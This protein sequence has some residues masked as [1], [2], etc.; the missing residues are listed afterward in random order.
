MLVAGQLVLSIAVHGG[1]GLPLLLRGSLGLVLGCAAIAAAMLAMAEGHERSAARVADLLGSRHLRSDLEAPVRDGDE[2]AGQERRFWRAYARSSVALCIFLAGILGI[3]VALLDRGVLAY[4]M[5]LSV[6]VA[7]L[8]LGS[9]YLAATALLAIR[10]DHVCL[11][12]SALLLAQLPGRPDASDRPPPPAR[13]VV[14]RSPSRY[15]HYLDR[16]RPA[17]D[18]TGS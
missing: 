11:H 17:Q 4:L 9:A 15:E 12:R 1:A 5:G 2:L 7:S 3:S 16:R 10:R 18:V 14:R 13:W 8:G 6:G